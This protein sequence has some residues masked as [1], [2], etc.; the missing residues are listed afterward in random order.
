MFYAE[1]VLWQ[2]NLK[3]D[4]W[5]K[6]NVDEH[7]GSKSP[8]VDAR[9][10]EFYKVRAS[11][12]LLL[13]EA[14]LLTLKYM[15]APKDDRR[16]AILTAGALSAGAAGIEVLA[17]GTELVLRHFSASS[18]T[19]V[20]ATVFLGQLKLAGGA[21]AVIGGA[22]VVGYDDDDATRAAKEG[23]HWLSRAYRIRYVTTIL[24]LTGQGSLALS[25]AHPM[26]KLLA[27]RATKTGSSALLGRASK[28]TGYFARKS[29][30][31]FLRKLLL[32]GTYVTIAVTA[33]IAIYDDDAIEKWCKK[34]I[35]RGQKIRDADQF[36]DTEIEVAELYAALLEVV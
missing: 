34:T 16:T 35:Y 9:S 25:A 26:I 17:A 18:T 4:E 5:F 21:L 2:T 6:E 3:S 36:K 23:N 7:K 22:I 28:V 15:D 32:R 24:M 13:L 19:S 20:G 14:G 29:T 31:V 8:L 30:T 27:E 33:V 11:G 1:W 12:W 10:S